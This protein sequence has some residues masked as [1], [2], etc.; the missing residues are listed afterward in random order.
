MP[1]LPMSTLLN[2]A[3]KGGYAVGAF[4]TNNLEYLRAI[5]QAAEEMQAPVIIQAAESEVDYMG[6]YLFL[7]MVRRLTAEMT[8]P[9]SVHLD[10]GPSYQT[11]MRCIRYG[12]SSVMFDGSLLPF[13]QNIATTRKVVEAAHAVGISVEGEFGLIGGT[14]DV[15]G[16]GGESA[17][18]DPEQCEIF[19]RETGVDCFAAS[20]GT[21]HGLYRSEPKLD[22]ARLDEIVRRT[23]VPI[24]LHGGSGVPEKDVREAIRRGVAKINFSTIVRKAAIDELKATLR[25]YPEQLDFMWI[26]D[27][28]SAKMKDAVKSMMAM[29]GSEGRAWI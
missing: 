20:I 17:L 2:E 8:V 25:D 13:D 21:A 14:D 27:R 3:L 16:Y 29:T 7:D 9:F 15:E 23:G 11:A 4:N 18:S 6:G 12:F 24:V 26:L 5:L 10:H 22:F 28:S 19:V 1:M